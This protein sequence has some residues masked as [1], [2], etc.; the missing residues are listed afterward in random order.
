[1][2]GKMHLDPK[3]ALHGSPHVFG[4]MIEAHVGI[5]RRGLVAFLLYWVEDPL[6]PLHSQNTGSLRSYEVC[7][8]LYSEGR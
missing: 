5:S 7:E 3:H 6:Y 1:M 4:A 8:R 2:L